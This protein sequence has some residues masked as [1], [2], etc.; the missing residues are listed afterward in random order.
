MTSQNIISFDNLPADPSSNRFPENIFSMLGANITRIQNYP[1]TVPPTYDASYIS[2]NWTYQSTNGGTNQW[3]VLVNTSYQVTVTFNTP[4][5]FNLIVPGT[6]ITLYINVKICNSHCNIL[7]N[8]IRIAYVCRVDKS[9]N[10]YCGSGHR[11][12]IQYANAAAAAA[13]AAAQSPA[14]LSI[15]G[16]AREDETLIAVFSAGGGGINGNETY[17]IWRNIRYYL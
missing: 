15:T 2:G 7:S 13:Q 17:Q 4:F 10:N 9:L 3:E 8:K 12:E 5:F 6:D 11:E 1:I 14:T 16:T